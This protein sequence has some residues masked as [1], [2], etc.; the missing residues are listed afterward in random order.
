MTIQSNIA[1]Y[2]ELISC[3]Q[4]LYMW[5]YDDKGNLCET[6]CPV[7]HLYKSIFIH[8]DN[9]AYI[10]GVEEK[11][12]ILLTNNWGLTW[13]AAREWDE[14]RPGNI[15]VIGPSILNTIS[16]ESME[17]KL[18]DVR[19]L[20][21]ASSSW[22]ET[23]INAVKHI[24]TTSF[25]DVCQFAVMLHYCVTGEK[26]KA[27]S[28][29][30]QADPE[31]L[32][33]D[34]QKARDRL[35]WSRTE[36]ALLQMIREGNADTTVLSSKVQGKEPPLYTD[37]SLRN[38]QIS[39]TVFAG[40][41]VRAAIDGGLSSDLCHTLGDNYI[42]EI[43]SARKIS[44]LA[45]INN[46]M[47]A[48]FIRRVRH[49]HENKTC[50]AAVKSCMDYIDT[51][52]EEQLNIELLS[53]RLGYTKYYLSRRFS[54]EVGMTINEY[55]K[56]AKIQ[57]ARQLLETTNESVDGIADKLGFSSR[58]FFADTFKKVTGMT[59]SQYRSQALRY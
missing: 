33:S 17:S 52:I 11:T 34:Q 47:Y 57:R 2:Q 7:A 50:S 1:L 27:D 55:I 3:N 25:M 45:S 42:R 53:S 10:D 39:C 31:R 4:P 43:W 9:L 26:L 16:P 44:A 23:F 19:T 51:H 21:H 49:L 28:I 46:H 12:P 24:P 40:L 54:Q 48:D 35:L 18:L 20:A 56:K 6:N 37:D 13:I 15:Y 30:Y 32:E 29:H 38:H 22:K 5:K 58:S 14:D 36:R 41:C 8:D 59:A